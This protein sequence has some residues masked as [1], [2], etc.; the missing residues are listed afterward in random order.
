MYW[1][2]GHAAVWLRD[3]ARAERLVGLLEALS[4]RGLW[5]TA[6]IRGL[7]AG[8]AALAGRPT[9][10]IGAFTDAARTLRELGLPLDTALLLMDEAATIGV[11]DPAGRAAADEAHEILTRLGAVVLLDRLD[12]LAG[13]A[14][15]PPAAE[16]AEAA[17]EAAAT[18]SGLESV[19]SSS[20]RS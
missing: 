6:S 1:L 5:T 13:G 2:A 20:A 7:N 4:V 8:I 11:G 19:S 9:D 16:S 17:A 3:R 10:A 14:T 15:A 18:Q 12:A